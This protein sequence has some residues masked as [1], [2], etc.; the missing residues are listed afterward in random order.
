[1]KY[2]TRDK[3]SFYTGDD[4]FSI[5]QEISEAVASLRNNSDGKY[6]ILKW[7]IDKINR[8]KAIVKLLYVGD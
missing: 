8:N 3:N 5:Q 1:M 7:T 6:D 2:E 4:E